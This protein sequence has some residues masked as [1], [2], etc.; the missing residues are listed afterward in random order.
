M[1]FKTSSERDNEMNKTKQTESNDHFLNYRFYN[2]SG[3]LKSSLKTLN[4]R[5]MGLNQMNFAINLLWN[6]G[7]WYCSCFFGE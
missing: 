2:K 1:Y 7:S 6:V 3:F 4:I 5:K